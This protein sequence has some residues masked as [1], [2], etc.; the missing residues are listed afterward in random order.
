MG[1]SDSTDSTGSAGTMREIVENL[2]S[3]LERYILVSDPK[4]LDIIALWIIHT[5]LAEETYTSPRLL[6]DSPVPGSGKTTLL[7][8]IG[9]FAKAPAQMALISSSAL[10]GRITANGIR[11]LLIDEAD[12]A[13]D[14]KKPGVGD[15][16]ALL[17]S[18]YKRGSTRPVNVQKN[19]DWEIVEMPT[20]SPVAIAG[21]TPLLP[22][23]TRSRCIVVRLLPD[24]SGVALESDWEVLDLPAYQFKLDIEATCE[25]YREEVKTLVPQLPRECRNRFKEKWKPL[26][27]IATL[28]G[29]EWIT[30]IN[31]YI[32]ADIQ[33]VKEQAEN[34][35][36]KISA[37]IQLLKDLYEIYKNQ[38]GFVATS[39]L[40]Y[41]LTRLN[42]E[43][44][45]DSTYYARGLTPQRIGRLI[46][47]KLGIN[48]QRE[49]PGEGSRGYHSRQFESLWRQLGISPLKTDKPDKPAETDREGGTNGS[50]W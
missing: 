35:E 27:K 10:L 48:S 49:K 29:S 9:K 12:R 22:E 13:L 15:L 7:E 23:D 3:W 6:I 30:K 47:G 17:N 28:A 46:N 38:P 11:T 19:K 41:E 44:W 14:P 50:T 8:H 43:Y 21:N 4:D 2:R 45:G 18:G 25:I 40:I 5:H 39:T 26:A 42:P 20:Y 37:H 16:I 32:K 31:E 33:S 1:F 34:G 36:A 24:I